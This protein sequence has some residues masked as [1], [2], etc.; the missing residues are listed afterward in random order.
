MRTPE[1][2]AES[3]RA[4]RDANRAKLAEYN[5]ARYAANK[6]KKAEYSRARYAEKRLRER[7]EK[8]LPM[9]GEG[10]VPETYK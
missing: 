3:K 4:W 10:S 9:Q 5:R 8:G 2:I 1:E 7:L 6:A